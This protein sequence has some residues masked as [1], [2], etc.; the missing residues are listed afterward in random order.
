MTLTFISIGPALDAYIVKFLKY[1]TEDWTLLYAISKLINRNDWSTLIDK[2]FKNERVETA[3][4]LNMVGALRLKK[5]LF[6]NKKINN[7]NWILYFGFSIEQLA[8]SFHQNWLSNL[9]SFLLGSCSRIG[10]LKRPRLWPLEQF[11]SDIKAKSHLEIKLLF[12]KL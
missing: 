4:T 12:I 10:R 11:C 1:P 2:S 3:F 7:F 8:Y 5:K 9:E 6:F